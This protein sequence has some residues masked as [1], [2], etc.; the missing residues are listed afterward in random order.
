MAQG[1]VKW[2]DDY[3]GFGFISVDGEDKDIFAHYSNINGEEDTRKTIT[4]GQNVTFDVES[5][6]KG[7]IATNI[8]V[9]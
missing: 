4:E 7:E 3:K 1:T 9:V 5:S 6:D 8:S 2:F